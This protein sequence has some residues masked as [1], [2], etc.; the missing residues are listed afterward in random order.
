MQRLSVSVDSK[1]LQ[2]STRH[3]NNYMNIYP[4]A[5]YSLDKLFEQE[6]PEGERLRKKPKISRQSEDNNG[7]NPGAVAGLAVAIVS[8]LL[9][10]RI[11][12]YFRTKLPPPRQVYLLPIVSFRP[13]CFPHEEREGQ[14]TAWSVVSD[15]ARPWMTVCLSLLLPYVAKPSDYFYKNT[16]EPITKIVNNRFF[17]DLLKSLC[18]DRPTPDVTPP[19]LLHGCMESMP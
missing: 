2:T 18:S 7:F 15:D 10:L 6:A 3:G 19:E 9:S 8:A 5:E 4:C 17:E 11:R 12:V 16:G 1:K 13:S 14:G